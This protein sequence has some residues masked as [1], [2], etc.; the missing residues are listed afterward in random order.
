MRAKR[1][2][3]R[4]ERRRQL[5]LAARRVFSERGYHATTV[6]EITREAGVAKGTF[7]LYFTEKREIFVDLIQSFFDLITQVG[8]SVSQQ[9][10]NQADFLSRVTQAA[11]E[12]ARI[13]SENR[14][15]VRLA[16]RNAMG[17]DEEMENRARQFYHRLAQLEAENIRVGIQ[18]GLFRKDLNLLVAAYAHIG[19]GERLLLQGLFD[20]SF[21]QDVDL[22]KELLL[23]AYSGLMRPGEEQF[24]AAPTVKGARA[25]RRGKTPTLTRGG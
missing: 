3:D 2:S 15:L 21:P 5:L 1:T 24:L 9:V 22:V 13:F 19:M 4:D 8:Q 18:L 11:Q 12:L 25:M 6:E 20:R 14:D 23:L 17:I 16:Y 7:Y 10:S